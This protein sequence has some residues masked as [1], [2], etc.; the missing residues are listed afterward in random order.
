MPA[1]DLLVPPEPEPASP[2]PGSDLGALP[3]ALS[4]LRSMFKGLAFTDTATDLW[5]G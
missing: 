1:E 3:G 2:E 4:T 5:I